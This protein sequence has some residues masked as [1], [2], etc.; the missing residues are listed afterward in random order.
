VS[1]LIMHGDGSYTIQ[2]ADPNYG[3]PVTIQQLASHILGRQAST[4]ADY[5]EAKLPMMGGCEVCHA[6][7]AAYNSCPSKTGYIR[8]QHGC[9]ADMGYETVEEAYKAL[10]Q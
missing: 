10:F 7:V 8:C 6:T 9:I 2:A 4:G 3:G 1:E 5:Q